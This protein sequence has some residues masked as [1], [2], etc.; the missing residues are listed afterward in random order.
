VGSREFDPTGSHQFFK[1][2]VGIIYGKP[3]RD[4]TRHLG[5][6]RGLKGLLHMLNEIVSPTI[7]DLCFML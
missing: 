6:P 4:Y 5:S 2:F 1:M 3:A 7:A